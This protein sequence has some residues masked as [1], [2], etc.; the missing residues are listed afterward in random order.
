MYCVGIDVNKVRDC[1]GDPNDDSENEILKGEQEAQV[2][3]GF[4]TVISNFY[5]M[6]INHA[7]HLFLFFFIICKIGNDSRG[8]V[9]M[10]PTLLVNNVQYRGMVH[11][12]LHI[13]SPFNRS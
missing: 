7:K 10:L 12:V 11:N 3:H 1:M 5:Q 9:T 8:D 13:Q 4:Y 2:P 6:I